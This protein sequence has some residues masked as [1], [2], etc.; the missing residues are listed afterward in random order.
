MNVNSK[1]RAGPV[2]STTTSR[3]FTNKQA[4]SPKGTFRSMSRPDLYPSVNTAI[5]SASAGSSLEMVQQM[6]KVLQRIHDSKEYAAQV[7]DAAQRGNEKEVIRLLKSVQISADISV[8]FTPD[9]LHMRFSSGPAEN[10]CCNTEVTLRWNKRN[11]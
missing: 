11:E 5:F 6:N 3:P 9:G 1:R 2:R 7:M 8:K 10:Y 4:M